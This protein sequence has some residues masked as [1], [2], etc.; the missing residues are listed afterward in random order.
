[1]ATVGQEPSSDREAGTGRGWRHRC[2]GGIPRT[3]RCSKEPVSLAH[4]GTQNWGGPEWDPCPEAAC[5]PELAS[6]QA[7]L[8]AAGLPGGVLT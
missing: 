7:T 8:G 6:G 5:A 3:Q 2:P 1:M 4:P